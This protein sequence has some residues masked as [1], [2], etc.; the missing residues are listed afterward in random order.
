MKAGL[1]VDVEVAS[2]IELASELLAMTWDEDSSAS[3]VRRFVS[4]PKGCYLL[5]CPMY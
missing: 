2:M 3:A 1:E 4:G 5:V